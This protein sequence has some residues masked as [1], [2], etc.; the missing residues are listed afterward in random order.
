MLVITLFLL[1]FIFILFILFTAIDFTFKIS[2][3][4]LEEKKEL[5]GIFTVKWLLFSHTFSLEEP[6]ENDSFPE[7]PDIV[8]KDQTIKE[9]KN[10]VGL[11]ENEKILVTTETS[12]KAEVRKGVETEEKWL[13]EKKIEVDWD[14]AKEI[15]DENKRKKVDKEKE[16]RIEINENKEKKGIIARIRG[17]KKLKIQE[18]PEEGMTTREMLNWIIEAFK[19]L[20]RP[21]FRLFSDLLNGIKIKRLESD[22]T[23]GLSDPADTGMLCGFIHAIAG[24]TYSRCKHCSF[25][26]NPVFMNPMVDFRGDIEAHVKL[27][28]L[29]FPTLK[30]I[31]N[32]KTLSFTYSIIKKKLWGKWKFNS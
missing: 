15:K 14:K 16:K 29:I 11:E 31:L 8:K 23:F 17:K 22:I 28:S 24:L 20:R 26:I 7:E 27:Y 4:I 3:L 12:Y 6:K 18:S 19:S 10:E 25:S 1:V 13:D 5:K 2:M 9:E 21:L 32:R 30:F